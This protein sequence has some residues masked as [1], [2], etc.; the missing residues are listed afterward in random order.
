MFHNLAIYFYE[1]LVAT[2][3][4][5]VRER[6]ADTSG[7]YRHLRTAAQCAN[8]LFHFREHLT[9][10]HTMTWR[11]VYDECPDYRLIANIANTTKHH[12]LTQN[13][14]IGPPLVARVEDL[15]EVRVI[16][17]YEDEQGDY[18]DARTL[19]SAMCSDGVER[20]VDVA[21][22]NVLNF[23]GGKLQA[24][25]IT[26][27]VARSTPERPGTRWLSR[28]EI[29]P[30]N[31]EALQ[32][33]D[34]TQQFQLLEWDAEAGRAKPKDLTG[35]KIEFRIYK[36]SYK[37]G[38]GF[39]HPDHPDEEPIEIE[40]DLTDEESARVHVAKTDAE[41]EATYRELADARQEEISTRVMEMIE[42]RNR[43][44]DDVS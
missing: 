43:V 14:P 29:R 38:I 11:E 5:Y 36:P 27:F 28:E 20:D 2:Y 33:I 19:V 13:D 42:S 34:F 9:D 25:G 16:V 31:L 6:D 23:W 30:G 3:D 35:S 21:L 17:R 26:K 39:T 4:A 41:R 10:P 22:T 37:L 7:R 12:E 15:K 24:W 44:G 32:G 8:V 18:S 1:N 40:F